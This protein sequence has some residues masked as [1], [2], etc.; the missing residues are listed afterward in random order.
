[1]L[2]N[3]KGPQGN[4]LTP[5]LVD[6][7]NDGNV[8]I[9]A[10]GTMTCT[11]NAGFAGQDTFTY[12]DSDGVGTDT[13][14]VGTV[15]IHVLNTATTVAASASTAVFGERVTFKATVASESGKT[16]TGTVTFMSGTKLLGTARLSTRNGE[17][18]ATLATS[19]LLAGTHAITALYGGD[20]NDTG[21]ASTALPVTI[22]QGSTAT[23]LAASARPGSLG[24]P[25]TFTATVTVSAQGA[26]APV[27]IVTFKDGTTVLG[28]AKLSTSKGVTKA[29]FTT[30]RL[31]LGTHAITAVY[32]GSANDRG[33][34]SPV[35]TM[36]VKSPATA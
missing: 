35:L 21:S 24:K 23:A 31:S 22:G 20:A 34:S 10:D 1:M 28:T 5:E 26:G 30:S 11:P 6:S 25:E 18:T 16:P 3:D 32:G 29:T 36:K 4:A 2:A 8:T 14:S 17:T 13:S 15:V 27:G 33:S 19:G 9:N 7:P 12:Q